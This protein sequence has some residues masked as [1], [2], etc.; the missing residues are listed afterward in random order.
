MK[1]AL[2]H[3]L[4]GVVT[5]LAALTFVPLASAA[6][7]DADR[8]KVLAYT[9]L[10]CHGIEGYRNAYPSYRV[11]ML[12]GQ[13]PEYIGIALR[14]Y[15]SG[16]RSHSTMQAQAASLSDEDISDLAAYFAR[17][18]EPKLAESNKP[19]PEKAALCASCHGQNGV[20]IAPINPT[21]AGQH[22]D[23][24]INA[25][26]QYQGNTVNERKNA[27]MAGLVTTLDEKDIRQLAEYY[28]S[29]SGLFTTREE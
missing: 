3:A 20:G 28:A 12:G 18:G 29:F 2:R 25:L 11:P 9:C 10:G 21:L 24:L 5:G 15:R 7:G 16:E 22:K 26:K 17:K 4:L 19:V 23:Y 13:S 14:A 6:D 8:G 1:N 27:V